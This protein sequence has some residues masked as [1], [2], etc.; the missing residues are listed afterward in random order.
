[1][2]HIIPILGPVTRRVAVPE[3]TLEHWASMYVTYRYRSKASLW[4]PTFGEDVDVRDF[5]GLPGK[6]VQ[7][8]LK[9][10][11][12]AGEAQDVHIDLGQL[13]EYLNKPLFQQ[14]FYVF[15]WPNWSGEL[16]T[17]ARKRGIAV[18]ELAFSRS[19]ESGGLPIG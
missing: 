19:G 14:P 13:W 12:P 10:V 18:T 1:M 3:K 7:L 15:P 9:T 6:G 16:E 17:C 5:P 4:W 2:S 8:E 11:T